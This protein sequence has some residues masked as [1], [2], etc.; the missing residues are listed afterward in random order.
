MSAPVSVIL[1]R[2]GHDCETIGPDASLIEVTRRLSDRGIGALVVSR[3]ETSVEGIVSERDVVRAVAAADVAALERPVSS[4][5]S[6]P[7][8]TCQRTT[9]IDEVMAVMTERRV[10][11]LPVVDEGRL[12]G[13]VSIGDVVKWRIDELQADAERMQEYVSGSY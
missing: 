3:D 11:H 1:E 4:A 8:T 9:S 7:V 5:M 6:A 2:K 10:R 13:I 12:V